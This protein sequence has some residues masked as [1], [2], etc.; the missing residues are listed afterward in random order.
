MGI[1][2]QYQAVCDCC[3]ALGLFRDDIHEAINISR[4]GGWR[5]VERLLICPLCP[6]S[7]E[8]ENNDARV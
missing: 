8:P 7:D 6:R 1:R 5:V 3:G 4:Q 2:T